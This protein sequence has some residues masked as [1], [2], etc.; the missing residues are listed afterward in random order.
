VL[1]HAV[2]NSVATRR[3]RSDRFKCCVIDCLQ[4]YR[5][6]SVPRQDM[7][8]FCVMCCLQICRKRQCRVKICLNFRRILYTNCHNASLLWQFNL[9][10]TYSLQQICHNASLSSTI[11]LLVSYAECKSFSTSLCR[12]DVSSLMSHT[13]LYA[14]LSRRVTV[15]KKGLTLVTYC[16]QYLLTL[17]CREERFNCCVTHCRPIQISLNG[18]L[19]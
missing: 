2:H 3:R 13:V 1:S 9:R 7:F 11:R 14:N 4:I 10:G 6:A 17:H 19:S 5:N 15:V 18:S 12:E 8:S 16:T